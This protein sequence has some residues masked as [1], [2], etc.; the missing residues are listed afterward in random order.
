MSDKKSVLDEVQKKITVEIRTKTDPKEY[1]QTRDGL[2]VWS[3]FKERILLKAK[4]IKA[5]KKFELSSFV[6]TKWAT[7]EAIEKELPKKHLFSESDVC[8]IISELISKQSK[9]E[10]GTL[11]NNGYSNLF[12]TKAFVVSVRWS[13]GGWRV[14]TW[15][16]GGD[17]WS[18]DARVFSPVN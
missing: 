2:Y 16:R 10:D 12:Y 14:L 4:P 6:L 5:G 1:F 18:D 15:N 8:A 9:G 7:D 3:D 13:G 11:Q 17:G